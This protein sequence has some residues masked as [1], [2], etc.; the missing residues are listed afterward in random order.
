MPGEDSHRYLHQRLEMNTASLGEHTYLEAFR[1]KDSGSG[2]V[3]ELFHENTKI[4]HLGD[5]FYESVGEVIESFGEE[6]YT[7]FLTGVDHVDRPL[8]ELPEASEPA[9]SLADAMCSR[10]SVRSFERD[11][12]SVDQFST[13]LKYGCGMIRGELATV[14][15]TTLQYRAYPSGG[16]LYPVEPYIVV[17]DVEGVEPGIYYYSAREH[18]L[19]VVEQMDR[20][21]L[22]EAVDPFVRE[23]NSEYESASLLFL[24][25]GAFWKSKVKYGPRGYR[26]VLLEAGHLAQ[27]VQL[28]AAAMGLGSVN[29]GG[30]DER[31]IDDAL[32]VNGVDEST[33]YGFLVGTPTEDEQ[34]D[35]TSTEEEQMN[36][37]TLTEGG[38]MNDRTPAQGG[39]TD[40]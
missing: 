38:R 12:L 3:A 31:A 26:F 35:D 39:E 16:A 1:R 40:E 5:N 9:G 36:D 17:F 15:E 33:V 6:P 8:V 7:E 34:M 19:R 23:W 18:G 25:T 37:R 29:T 21:A 28:I 32:E 4:G 13:L 30:L 2:D 14:E 10:R 20:D 24:L 22:V 11:S 27:N